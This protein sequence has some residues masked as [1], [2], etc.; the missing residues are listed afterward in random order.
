MGMRVLAGREFEWRDDEKA[1]RVA[2]VS[3]SLARRLFPSESP[4]GRTVRL[5]EGQVRDHRDVQIVGVVNSASL[6]RI[7]SREPLAVY[8]PLVQ[9]PDPSPTVVIRTAIDPSAVAAGARRTIQSMGLHTTLRIQTL[10]ERADMFLA[11]ERL[12][13]MLS[14]SLG[15]LAL[16]LAAVGLYGLMSHAVTRRTAEIGIRMALGAQR[17]SVLGLILREVMWLVLAGIAVA[18]PVA[19]AASRLISGMLFG[20]P[21]NDPATMAWSAGVLAAVALFAGYLPARRASRIDPMTALRCE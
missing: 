15:G 1:P 17:G 12:I 18:I 3:E 6:W 4:V 5:P 13:A 8:T 16:L 20:L 11:D 10:E 9:E 19:V 7:Q 14:A 2:I 21:A